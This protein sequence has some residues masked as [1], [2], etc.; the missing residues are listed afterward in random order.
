MKILIAVDGSEAALNGARFAARLAAQL[1]E[2]AITLLYVRP[3]HTGALVGLGVPGP[4]DEARLERELSAVEGEILAEASAIL[5]KAGLR[6]EQSV[7]T[8]TAG[9]AICRVA[10]E[11]RFDLVVVGSRGHTELKSLLVG[12]TSAAVIHGAPCPV[13]VVR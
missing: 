12:S 1:A 3:S 9:P 11:G 13:L 8:G 5:E 6:A 10:A 2:R 7:E 4:R